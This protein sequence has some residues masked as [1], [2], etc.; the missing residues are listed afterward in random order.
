[1]KY[2]EIIADNLAKHGWSWGLGSIS[3]DDG[4]TIFV[5]DA[6]RGDG[7]RFVTRGHDLLT[8]FVTLEKTCSRVVNQDSVS[9]G[10]L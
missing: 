3:A 9:A 5:A 7:K 4:S 8:V 1:M 10:E 6:R 2:W